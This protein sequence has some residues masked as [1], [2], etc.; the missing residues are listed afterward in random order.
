MSPSPPPD[1]EDVG[2]VTRLLASVRQ[3]D[4]EAIDRVFSLVYAELR[5]A[6]K[7]QL[8]RIRP[9]ETINTTVLVHETYLKLVDAAK[10]DWNDRG[11][12]LAVA[13]KAM[14]QIVIDHARHAA[15]QKRGGGVRLIPLDSIDI[16]G[17]E[18]AGELVALDAALTRLEA[19]SEPLAR[20]V[21]L[22]FF[23]G[24]SIE[25]TAAVLRS[26]PHTVKRNWRKAR[27]FLYQAVQQP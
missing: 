9:G 25:E 20:L 4:R 2:Q 16:V 27:A 26:Q 13:A 12:F 3:G 8:A 19:F 6:A 21:E 24:L 22:R 7:R 11:H 17:E 10:A 14:R 15:R 1:D 18:R 5:S 23:A